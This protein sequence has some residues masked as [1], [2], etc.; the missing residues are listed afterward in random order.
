METVKKKPKIKLKII[1]EDLG[2]TALGQWRNRSLVTCGDNWDELRQM[3]IEMLNLAFEDLGY[4]YIIDEIQFEFDLESFFDFYKVINA[5]ALSERIGMS[6]S[7]LAQYINGNK[8]PSALQ[9]KRILLGVQQLG[10]ELAE[11]RF[12]L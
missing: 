11:V 4:T 1:K 9:T 8:K 10:R 3:I 2:Y 12:L 5:K 7:L 6:Q